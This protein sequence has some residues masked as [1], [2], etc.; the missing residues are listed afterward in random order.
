[1]LDSI[2]TIPIDFGMQEAIM[3]K[4]KKSE[5]E[6]ETHVTQKREQLTSVF[7]QRK[8][9]EP[10]L[11]PKTTPGKEKTVNI[12]KSISIKGDLT[13]DED[14]TIEGRLDGKIDLKAHN[15][16]VGP[17]GATKGEL[18]VRNLTVH[19]RVV[20]N[21][22][23]AELVEIKASGSVLGNIKSS[24]I[25]IEEGAYFKGSVDLRRSADTSGRVHS[26]EAGNSEKHAF[27]RTSGNLDVA[28]TY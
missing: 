12:G 2:I 9:M 7:D 28:V 3:W 10:R 26:S 24:R 4:S 19:G 8:P 11:E 27:G 5:E 21:V 14:L 17:H 1:M 22:S 25:S 15:L 18:N 13:G 20:G 6:V 23:A 16:V